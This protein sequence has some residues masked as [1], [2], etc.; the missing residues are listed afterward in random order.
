[1]DWRF[2]GGINWRGLFP[3]RDDDVTALA[4][5]REERTAWELLHRMPLAAKCWLQFTVLQ[6][7]P[8]DWRIGMTIGCDL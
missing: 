7:R 4:I 8:G 5:I 2:A 6:Q 3:H 1:M